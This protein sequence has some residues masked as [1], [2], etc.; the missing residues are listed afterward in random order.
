MCNRDDLILKP[1]LDS[2]PMKGIEYWGDVTVSLEMK[3]RFAIE[4]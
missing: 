3:K 2:K 4:R 1:L